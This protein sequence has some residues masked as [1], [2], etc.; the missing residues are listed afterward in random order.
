MKVTDESQAPLLDVMTNQQSNMVTIRKNVKSLHESV[1][2]L[3][4]EVKELREDMKT[5]KTEIPVLM[6]KVILL[7][8]NYQC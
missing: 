4:E 5:T 2:E 1:R 8:F 3:I 6:E 7:S